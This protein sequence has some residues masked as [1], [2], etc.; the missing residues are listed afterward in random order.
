MPQFKAPGCAVGIGGLLLLLAIGSS[1]QA[2]HSSPTAEGPEAAEESAPPV[3]GR[4]LETPPQPAAPASQPESLLLL[5]FSPP[6]GF[7]GPS[8]IAPSEEQQSSHFVPLEDR[9]RIGFPPWDRYGEGHPPLDD[10]PYQPGNVCDPFNLN[11][12][13]GDYPII[14]QHTFLD[15]TATSFTFFN[16]RSVPTQAT[17]FESPARPNTTGFFGLPQQA[18]AEEYLSL[19]VDLFHGDAAFK[20]VDWRIKITP[21]ANV[22]LLDVEE[23]G[24]V[25]PD[26]RKGTSRVRSFVTLEEWFAEYKIADLSPDYDF[27]SVRVGSQPLNSDFRGFIFA[28]TNRAVRFFGSAESNRDQFNVALF[29]QQEKDTDSDLNTFN[30][31]HQLVGVA[32]FFRQ[33]FVVPGYTAELNCVYDHD[34]PSLQYDKNGFL[35]RPDPVGVFTPHEVDVVYLGFNGDGHIGPYNISNAFY[36]ALGYDSLNPLANRGQE[37]SA[38]LAALELSY[39][40]DW[41]R[42]R[43]SG[44]FATGDGNPN[45]HHATGFDG[46]MD[47]PQFAGGPFSYWQSQS[48]PLFG[49]NLKN[50]GSFFPD[51]RA[52]KIQGQANFVNPGIKLANAG[53]D[54]ELTP[55]LRLINN[56]N[57]LGF[58]NTSSLEVLT[59]Q[60]DIHHFIGTDISSGVEYRP[61]LN[62]N[63]I[64]QVGIATLLPGRGFQEIY[65]PLNGTVR[66]LVSGLAQ[67]TLT[68]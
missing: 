27:L 61:L 48:I 52:S 43:I 34:E 21:V 68:Y 63:I 12:L 11:V 56:I 13:K 25:S 32:N 7:A 3:L 46:V 29:W 9:W 53:I 45:N 38:G 58:V 35:V 62:N 67:I 16:P 8:G 22:N 54:F 57:F 15:V 47:N 65:D 5:P 10:Y 64:F 24:V 1:I 33:D 42:F 31:R 55:K 36:W 18:L 14:G 59:F 49:T 40:R 37:I 17:I 6:T 39:D 41:A 2:Q 23:L 50:E 28:D 19:S 20:P 4:P 30:D 66:C 44:L 26:V 60:G 51:L